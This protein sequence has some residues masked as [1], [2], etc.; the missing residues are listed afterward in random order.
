MNIQLKFRGFLV[1][2]EVGIQSRLTC[3][4][5]TP[6]ILL[7]ACLHICKLIATAAE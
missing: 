3:D 4:C 7:E 6:K 5:I 2:S 1:E